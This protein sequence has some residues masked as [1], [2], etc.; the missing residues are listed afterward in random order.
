MLKIKKIDDVIIVETFCYKIHKR[1][2]DF[3]NIYLDIGVISLMTTRKL[4]FNIYKSDLYISISPHLS[5]I[6]E[7]VRFE[8]NKTGE[9]VGIFIEELILES[10]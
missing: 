4:E 1:V 3:F 8:H 5:S 6:L 7:T 10:I 9:E 2:L